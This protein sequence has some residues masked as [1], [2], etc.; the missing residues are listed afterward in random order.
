MAAGLPSARA[1]RQRSGA[2]LPA[3]VAVD[4]VDVRAVLEI[5]K[6][7]R[8]RFPTRI[9]ADF[10]PTE[11]LVARPALGDPEVVH[12][13]GASESLVRQSAVRIAVTGAQTDLAGRFPVELKQCRG[14]DFR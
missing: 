4:T 9:G 12:A 10:Q 1:R 11:G 2:V 13:I 6:P 14:I 3:Q 7:G 5:R 8:A